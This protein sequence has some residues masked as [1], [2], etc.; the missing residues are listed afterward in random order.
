MITFV[1]LLF[2]SALV[3]V[4]WP[5]QMGHVL[6]IWTGSHF[7]SYGFV[8]IHKGATKPAKVKKN[9]TKES[10][11]WAY[12][13]EQKTCKSEEKSTKGESWNWGDKGKLFYLVGIQLEGSRIF[14]LFSN[15]HALWCQA[16]ESRGS[17]LLFLWSRQKKNKKQRQIIL[18]MALFFL[19]PLDMPCNVLCCSRWVKKCCFYILWSLLHNSWGKWG[20]TE[21]STH[22]SAKKGM[23]VMQCGHSIIRSLLCNSW[24]K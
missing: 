24:G 1:A 16:V 17:P 12:T 5:C 9:S 3:C 20:Q 19:F 11:N 10:W 18:A 4:F 6:P 21:G 23:A 7:M 22:S 13:K 14:L 2:L 8:S 15:S